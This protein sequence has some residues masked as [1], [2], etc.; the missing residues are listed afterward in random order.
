MFQ[1]EAAGVY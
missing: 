1:F